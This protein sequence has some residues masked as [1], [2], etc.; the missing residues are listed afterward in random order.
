MQEDAK[1][2]CLQ[3]QWI[4]KTCVAEIKEKIIFE[5]QVQANSVVNSTKIIWSWH[6]EN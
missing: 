1:V 4:L 2:V 3:F 5:H 6:S